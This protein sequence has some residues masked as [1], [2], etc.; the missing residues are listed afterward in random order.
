MVIAIGVLA[1]RVVQGEARMRDGQLRSGRLTRL[2][3]SRTSPI[4]G[5]GAADSRKEG[6]WNIYDYT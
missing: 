2:M 3:Q 6:S 5:R 1:D 4:E